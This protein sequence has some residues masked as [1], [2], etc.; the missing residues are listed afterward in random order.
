MSWT[1]NNQEIC[2]AKSLKHEVKLS[3]QCKTENGIEADEK[4]IITKIIGNYEQVEVVNQYNQSYVIN[5]NQL[6]M[7]S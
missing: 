4:F 3:Y 2:M 6:I 5:T 7:E 1:M